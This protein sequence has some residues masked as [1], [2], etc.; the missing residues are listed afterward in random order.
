MSE[1][2]RRI[3]AEAGPRWSVPTPL[4][5]ELL[6]ETFGRDAPRLLDVGVGT[7]E[8]TVNWAEAHPTHDVVAVELNRPSMARLLADLEE[9]NLPNVRLLEADVTELVADLAN[10]A[11]DNR[12]PVIHAVRVLFPDPWPKRRHLQRR[13]VDQSFVA[14]V[15]DLLP[16]GGWLHLATDWDDYAL[17]MRAALCRE[18]RLTIDLDRSL[19]LTATTEPDQLDPDQLDPARW[20][21]TD[22]PRWQSRRPDRPVT[23]YEGRG[24]LAGRHITD[25]LAH[26]S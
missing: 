13:L 1:G 20:N 5:A 24:L 18:P 15:A 25:L 26:R 3:L 12:P 11:N 6:A 16:V 21:P 9:R 22:P 2:K 23:T 17:Q 14:A 19:D 7:G 8:A 4:R 10:L